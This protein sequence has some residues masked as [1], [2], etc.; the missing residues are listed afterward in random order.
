MKHAI[1]YVLVLILL[2]GSIPSLAED[3]YEQ[4]LIDDM[5]AA[6]EI[7]ERATESIT[8]FRSILY[9]SELDHVTVNGN[10]G[11]D[12]SGDFIALVY[13]NY[14]DC[15]DT[16]PSVD[17]DIAIRVSNTIADAISVD[18]PEVVELSIFWSF[19]QYDLEGKITYTIDE[20]GYHYGDAMFPTIMV[21]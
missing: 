3:D 6:P 10:W 5:N 17:K 11:T 12:E 18:C 2:L 20:D 7:Q 9:G 4:G 15:H 21:G 14:N 8:Y 16:M 19:V 13:M 1:L